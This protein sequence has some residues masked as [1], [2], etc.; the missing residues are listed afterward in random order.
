MSDLAHCSMSEYDHIQ[1]FLWEALRDWTSSIIEYLT[2]RIITALLIWM[3]IIE[4]DPRHSNIK[5]QLLEKTRF[6]CLQGILS[7]MT[8]RMVHIKEAGHMLWNLCQKRK[9]FGKSLPLEGKTI[10]EWALK[11][12]KQN[13]RSKGEKMYAYPLCA[14]GSLVIMKTIVVMLSIFFT[15][16]SW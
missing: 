1:C 2:P 10:S 3:T 9:W 8:I 6:R 5:S 16:V 15:A 4:P 13:M 14:K 7:M 12:V 11:C